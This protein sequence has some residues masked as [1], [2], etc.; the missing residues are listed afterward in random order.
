MTKCPKC[1][2]ELRVSEIDEHKYC[3]NRKCKGWFCL[4]CDDWHSF[5]T[6]CGDAELHSYNVTD[7]HSYDSW[8]NEHEEDL[9]MMLKDSGWMKG[10]EHEL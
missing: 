4:Y 5:G 8:C 1:G 10:A 2:E 3:M 7:Q 9:L 6:F